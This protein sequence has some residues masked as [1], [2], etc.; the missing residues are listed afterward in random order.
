MRQV[1]LR[2]AEGGL[3]GTTNEELAAEILV[4]GNPVFGDA[5]QGVVLELA[6]I[7]VLPIVANHLRHKLHRAAEGDD[8]LAGLPYSRF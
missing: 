6:G 8:G 5:Q 1:I 2:I 3:F 4:V 7:V